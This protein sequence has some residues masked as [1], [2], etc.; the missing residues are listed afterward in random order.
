M[1]KDSIS[2]RYAQAM[3]YIAIEKNEVERLENDLSMI[4]EVLKTEKSFSAFLESK[5]IKSQEK[6]ELIEKVFSD[7]ISEDAKNLLNVLVEKNREEYILEIVDEFQSIADDHR[8]I[9]LLDCYSS[10]EISEEEKEKIIKRFSEVLKKNIKI[11][12]N[13]DEKLLGGLKVKYKNQVIDGSVINKLD[14]YKKVLMK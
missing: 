3:L 6:I 4:K 10:V 5:L 12:T 2:K 8:G 7:V 14:Q 1:K 11:S 9:A 13:I